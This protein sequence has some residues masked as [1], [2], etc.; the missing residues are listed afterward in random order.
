MPYVIDVVYKETKVVETLVGRDRRPSA[1]VHELI[2]LRAA[3]L[4]SSA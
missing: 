1:N 2:P 3:V 4:E